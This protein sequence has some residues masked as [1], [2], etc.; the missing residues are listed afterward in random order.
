[1]IRTLNKFGIEGID[2]NIVEAM[3][4]K[5]TAN[6]IPHGENLKGCT[7]GLGT[8][9]GHPIS[10]LLCNIVLEVLAREIRQVKGTQI[11]KEEVKISVCR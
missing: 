11:R 2:C 10:S 3:Y 5:P 4:D 7:Q 9:Q 8:R 1:M 6:I